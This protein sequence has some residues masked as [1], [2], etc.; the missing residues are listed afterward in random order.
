MQPLL[1]WKSNVCHTFCVCVCVTLLIQHA[2]RKRRIILPPVAC[3]ALLCFSTLSHKRHDFQKK[4]VIEHKMC[5]LITS[6]SFT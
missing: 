3:P 1:Q 5:V 4:K 2:M 6:T